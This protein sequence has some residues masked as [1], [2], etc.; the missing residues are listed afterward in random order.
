MC[1]DHN[2]GPSCIK[3]VAPNPKFLQVGGW[4]NFNMRECY[5]EHTKGV[6]IAY[7]TSFLRFDYLVA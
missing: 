2:S 1:F 3:D 6:K 5:H 7:V 4:K